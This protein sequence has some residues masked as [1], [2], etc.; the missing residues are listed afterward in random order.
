MENQGTSDESL[1]TVSNHSVYLFC[2]FVLL[3]LKWGQALL[4]TASRLS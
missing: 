4:D 3:C 2:M 1:D